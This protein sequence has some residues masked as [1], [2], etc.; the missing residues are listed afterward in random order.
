MTR[1]LAE[2]M[3]VEI[4]DDR[5]SAML[6]IEADGI[7][8]PL[9]GPYADSLITSR[10]IPL[11]RERSA[12]ARQLLERYAA[13][14]NRAH[15]LQIASGM[16]PVHGLG[17]RLELLPE[18]DP[19][20]PAHHEAVQPPTDA[21]P[22][23][24]DHHARSNLH[25]VRAGEVVGR[26]HPP[27]PGTDGVDV[28]GRVVKAKSP[29]NPPIS[30]ED[31]ISIGP[32]GT[33]TAN[34]SGLLE[35]RD[36]RLRI[37]DTLSIH[38]P[39]DFSVGNI[40]FPGHVA[41]DGGVR[42]DFVVHA[43]GDARVRDLVE[44]AEVHAGRDLQLEIGMSARGKG[45]LRAGRDLHAKYLADVRAVVVRDAHIQK[46]ISNCEL[47]IG[48]DLRAA[49]C[50][51]MRGEL[52]VGRTCELAHAGT[53]AH[54]HTTIVL[55]KFESLEQAARQA[56]QLAPDVLAQ[57]ER[58][59]TALSTMQRA[60]AKLTPR[61]A[62][63]LTELQFQCSKD[64]STLRQLERGVRTIATQMSKFARAE[65]VVN[66]V[67]HPGVRVWIGGYCVEFHQAIRG[68]IRVALDEHGGPLCVDTSINEKHHL[69]SFARVRADPRFLDIEHEARNLGLCLHSIP[70]KAA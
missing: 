70:S 21:A 51:L 10:E 22:R 50:T 65:L 8:G 68:P 56:L 47:R 34:I 4:A 28:F 32:D 15:R 55:G 60:T 63:E 40:E 38:G 61:Q 1:A 62:E 64:E 24:V 20:A 2:L 36:R 41:L 49:A 35:S 17:T 59:R 39:V 26:L 5:M 37:S 16:E 6:V 52:W 9:D 66:G 45:S 57:H 69:A 14:P 18:F 44:A 25:A 27:K 43:G 12:L 54:V 58:S 53:E 31:S 19:D 7:P 48:R 23:R 11:T 13:E 46:D 29:R 30:I 3:R 42:D 33:L 67:I